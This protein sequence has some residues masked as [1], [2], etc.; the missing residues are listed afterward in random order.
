MATL[1]STAPSKYTAFD[2][3]LAQSTPVLCSGERDI[4]RMARAL[5]NSLVVVAAFCHI[6]LSKSECQDRPGESTLSMWPL[7]L[8]SV[9][10]K[11]GPKTLVGMGRATGDAA[12]TAQLYDL[13]VHPRMRGFGI[14]RQ[15]VRML[16]RQL[17]SKGIYD[18][19]TI[20]PRAVEPFFR[21][22]AVWFG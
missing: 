20:C 1:S 6:D 15:I 18:V 9:L 12:L 22:C 5:D 16:V 21:R 3:R 11:A 14:G 19:G 2:A 10:P 4:E 8:S 17:Q 13:A 7:H